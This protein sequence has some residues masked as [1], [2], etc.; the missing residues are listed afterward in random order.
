VWRKRRWL[1]WKLRNESFNEPEIAGKRRLDKNTPPLVACAVVLVIALI[2]NIPAPS[3]LWNPILVTEKS[4]AWRQAQDWA[5]LNTSPDVKFL[6]PPHPFGFRMFS[7]RGIWVD[8]IDGNLVH[9]YPG[10]ADE[11]RQ[12]MAAI[13]VTLK[14]GEYIPARQV[15]QYKEQAWDKLEALARAQRLSY[16]IQYSDV[17]YDIRPVFKNKLYA[18]YPVFAQDSDR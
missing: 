7:E 4:K 13:G 16:V 12:R 3:R 17:K 15:A 8:W 1:Q 18:I 6:V 10:Y 14:I 9:T 5:K 2:G 11:W